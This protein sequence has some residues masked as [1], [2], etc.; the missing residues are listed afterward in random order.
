MAWFR[1]QGFLAADIGRAGLDY[2][3]WRNFAS[4]PDQL[5]QRMVFALS[6]FLVVSIEGI[7]TWASSPL[8]GWRTRRRAGRPAQL[9]EELL[10]E[11]E[12]PLA[13]FGPSDIR[14][15]DRAILVPD[16]GPQA[17]VPMACG[18]LAWPHSLC[19][20]VGILD[21]LAHRPAKRGTT[22]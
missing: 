21:G 6:Q 18:A 14:N 3:V 19:F 4:S 9:R 17:Q 20:R 12:V 8:T 13:F 16:S 22:H 15:V 1:D 2:T 5:R 11:L 10:E 7:G